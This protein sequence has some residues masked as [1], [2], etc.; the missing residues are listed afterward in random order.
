MEDMAEGMGNNGVALAEDVF[1]DL[2][3]ND[4]TELAKQIAHLINNY[5]EKNIRKNCL[6]YTVLAGEAVTMHYGGKE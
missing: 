1:M 4:R 3:D 5:V 6:G 2:D